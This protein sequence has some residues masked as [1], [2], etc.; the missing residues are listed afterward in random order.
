MI[1]GAFAFLFLSPPAFMKKR[2]L[3]RAETFSPS[4]KKISEAYNNYSKT[5]PIQAHFASI[6]GQPER[7]Y[8]HAEILAIIRAGERK[9]HTIKVTNLNGKLSTPCPVCMAAIKAYGISRVITSTDDFS[10]GM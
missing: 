6:A 3:L 9:I 1:G 8:L 10:K 7:K 2:Y 4:G 5:H